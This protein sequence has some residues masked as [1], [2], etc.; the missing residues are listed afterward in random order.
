MGLVYA[1]ITLE[2]SVDA[3]LAQQGDIPSEN[4]RKMEIKSLVDT[5]KL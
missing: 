2:N 3:V 5:D 1:D 4:V